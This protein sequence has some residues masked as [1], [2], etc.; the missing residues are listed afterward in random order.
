MEDMKFFELLAVVLVVI[1][2]LIVYLD[3]KRATC[4]FQLMSSEKLREV[5][6]GPTLLQKT[7]P[8]KYNM[9]VLYLS[10]NS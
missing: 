3:F 8:G 2:G 4:H 5:L 9:N 6:S 1:S 10:K 7:I